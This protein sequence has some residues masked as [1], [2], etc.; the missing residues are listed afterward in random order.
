MKKCLMLMV[1]GLMLVSCSHSDKKYPPGKDTIRSFGDGTFELL[2]GYDF[3]NNRDVKTLYNHGEKDI[4]KRNVAQNIV[5]FKLE[6]D[7]VY[8][9][10]DQQRFIKEHN[11][12]STDLRPI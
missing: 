10:D 2:R 12:Q 8:L 7:Y 6:G 1:I 11:I 9:L 5:T 4:V 3:N